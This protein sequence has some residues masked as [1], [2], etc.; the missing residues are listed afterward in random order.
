MVKHLLLYNYCGQH[1]E[2]LIFFIIYYQISTGTC[3]I[4]FISVPSFQSLSTADYI[5]IINVFNYCVQFP[6][7]MK[8]FMQAN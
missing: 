2:A 6:G 7:C 8:M 4:L 3:I 1:V 5:V